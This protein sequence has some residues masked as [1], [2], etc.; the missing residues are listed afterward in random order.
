[1]NVC[2]I[3]ARGGSKRIPRKNIR[4]FA[5]KPIIAWSIETALASGCFDEVVV[6]TDDPAIIDV[7]IR[8][9]ATAPF[10]R[11]PELA[12]DYVATLPVVT[13]AID[14]MPECHDGMICCLY[15]TAPLLSIDDLLRGSELIR[16]SEA[17]FV[18][19]VTSYD[20]PIQRALSVDGTGFLRM[21]DDSQLSTRTQDLEEVW[22]D[23]G[24][25]YFG[26]GSSW[27]NA[28]QIFSENTVP[29]VLKRSNVVDIDTIEDWDLAEAIFLAR[30]QVNRD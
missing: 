8:Y 9:G 21:I 14:Q 11:P 28:T 15:P 24:Q 10:I 18:C 27:I 4:P 20:Y 19:S 23:A 22:H 7:A 13:H 25:F 6:S 3:P 2:V 12:G 16:E 30:T 5:G 17:D 26:F 1:M 29:L